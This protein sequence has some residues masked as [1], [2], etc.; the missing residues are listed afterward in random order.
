MDWKRILERKYLKMERLDKVLGKV[1]I[2][3]VTPFKKDGSVDEQ[4]LGELAYMVIERGFGDSII[5]SGTTGEFVSLSMEERKRIFQVV[6]DAVGNKIPIIAGTGAACTQHAIQLTQEAEKLGYTVAMVVAPYY[7]KPTQA[8]IYEH[9]RRVAA[10]T[11]LPI[12]LYNI[13]L[14]TGVNIDASTLKELVKIPNIRAIKEEAGINP[15]QASEYALVAD[16]DFVIYC[17]DDTMVIQ[18][19][20]QGGKGVVSGGSLVVGN[21]MKEMINSYEKGDVSSTQSLQLKLYEFFHSFNQNGRVNPIPLIRTAVSLTWKDVGD[22][23]LP[24]LP[25]TQEEKMELS[26]ILKKL[27]ILP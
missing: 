21:L 8:G 6:R 17:G 11:S 16:K 20:S 7:Q 19:L 18:V 1:I 23:R 2:P 24:L 27:N 12:M 14:F 26:R 25:A 9:Y 4:L 22:P 3:L 5:V 13:P 10:S 15:T